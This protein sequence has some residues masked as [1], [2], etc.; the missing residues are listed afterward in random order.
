MLC[1]SIV[2]IIILSTFW[3]NLLYS[4]LHDE[5]RFF[6]RLISKEMI[7]NNLK[8]RSFSITEQDFDMWTSY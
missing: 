3:I 5:E 8:L 7:L 1:V 4:E 2:E 6:E